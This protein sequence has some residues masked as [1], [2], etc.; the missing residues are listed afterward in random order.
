MIKCKHCGEVLHEVEADCFLMDGD[1]DWFPFPIT[2]EEDGGALFRL[3]IEWCGADLSDGEREDCIRC[4]KCR[5]YPFSE[6]ISMNVRPYLEVVSF[7]SETEEERWNGIF[8][9]GT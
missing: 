7:D 9:E 8:K 2:S 6:T 3:P 5:E 1:D 4:P